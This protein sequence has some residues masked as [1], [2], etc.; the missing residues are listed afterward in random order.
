MTRKLLTPSRLMCH[1]EAVLQRRMGELAARGDLEAAC[2]V[3]AV[4]REVSE[5]RALA[6]AS[7]ASGAYLN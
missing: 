3:R 5:L 4:L 2:R 1:H 6:A 7:E